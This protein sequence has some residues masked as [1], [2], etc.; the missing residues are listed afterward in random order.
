MFLAEKTQHYDIQHNGSVIMLSIVM[1]IVVMLSVIMMSVVM[2]SVV[3][4]SVIMRNVVVP[5]WPYPHCIIEFKEISWSV[6]RRQNRMLQSKT[7][8]ILQFL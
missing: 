6:A 7:Y 3:M 8:C 1:P 2:L 5:F 4:L